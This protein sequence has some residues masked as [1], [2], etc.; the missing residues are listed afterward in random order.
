MNAVFD[1]NRFINL[2]RRNLLNHKNHFC[3][4]SLAIIGYSIF[5]LL[6]FYITGMGLFMRSIYPLCVVFIA[7]LPGFFEK[8]IRKENSTFDM[9]LPASTFE[10]YLILIINYTI[11][12][13]LICF[14][15]IS[16]IGL[17]TEL[18]VGAD[19]SSIIQEALSFSQN[20]TIKR[21]LETLGFQSIILVGYTYFKRFSVVK[22]TLIIVG[23]VVTLQIVFLIATIIIIGSA[24][25]LAAINIKL[26]QQADNSF[27][28]ELYNK[29]KII[30]E[31]VLTMIFP[32][33]LWVVGF[34]KLRE[35]EI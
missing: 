3:Y 4:A 7:F 6:L 17:I 28:L 8:G 24:E 1:L 13:P 2:E 34:L 15:V 14:G 33:G 12:I 26:S 32:F 19:K 9:L 20:F 25:S 11:I 35:K 5:T 30:S 18:F 16:V 31:I 21:Y 10:K 23:I 22:T 27:I 29:I